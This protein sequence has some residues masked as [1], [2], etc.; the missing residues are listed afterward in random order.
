MMG[1]QDIESVPETA[2][3]GGGGAELGREPPA[4]ARPWVICAARGLEGLRLEPR[5]VSPHQQSIQRKHEACAHRFTSQDVHHGI[6]YNS[7]QLAP[8]HVR[9][10]GD[11][12]V[13]DGAPAAGINA[14]RPLHAR[15]TQSV[16]GRGKMFVLY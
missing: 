12:E 3:G 4:G 2:R 9:S 5:S 1:S 10:E 8:T 16:H 6:I 15:L 14:M 13:D 7:Q 11:G